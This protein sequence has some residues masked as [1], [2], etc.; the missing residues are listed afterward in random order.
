MTEVILPVAP[1]L[2]EIGTADGVDVRVQNELDQRGGSR[3]D[4]TIP[5]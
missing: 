1:Q 3:Q 2:H 4:E 5:R